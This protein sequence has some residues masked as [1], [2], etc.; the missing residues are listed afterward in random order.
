MIVSNPPFF[1]QSFKST[2]EQRSNARHADV[3]PFEELID[4]AANLLNKFGVFSVIIPCKEEEKFIQP[5]EV[6]FL[7]GQPI[8]VERNE[9]IEKEQTSE[10]IQKLN[11][12]PMEERESFIEEEEIDKR[13]LRR[14]E[15]PVSKKQNTANF[16]SYFKKRFKYMIENHDNIVSRFT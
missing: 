10:L 8:N 5:E 1:E 13:V 3:L 9:E 16:R 2:D 12:L 14:L 7:D 11:E 4:S 15:I 6:R